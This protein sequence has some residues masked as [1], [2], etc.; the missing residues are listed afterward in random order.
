[1]I[2]VKTILFDLDGVVID[3]ESI[4]AKS[5]RLTLA[6]F[7]IDYPETLFKDY[8]GIPDTVFFNDVSNNLD[9][10]K[11]PP[12]LF[13]SSKKMFYK[14]LLKELKLIDG[15][16]SFIEK[17]KDIGIRSALVTS[18]SADYLGPVDE[19]F[20]LTRLFDIVITEADTERHKPFPDP[21][22]KPLEMLHANACNTIVI[23]DSPNGII[24]AKNAGCFV[25]GLMG[26]FQRNILKKAGA[27]EIVES[28]QGLME[29]F[30]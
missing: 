16:L 15:F 4:H 2:D 1:M 24:S 26:T 20:H 10:Q 7:N 25:Y 12:D 23:E 14:E 13:I 11:R 17:V 19:L 6:R 8:K 30:N 27:D 9:P 18:S 22:L 3:S 5:E 29:K 21:Y 28:Y